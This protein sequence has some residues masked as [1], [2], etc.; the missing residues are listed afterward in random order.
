MNIGQ[1]D[2]YK[3]FKIGKQLSIITFLFFFTLNFD[4][5]TVSRIYLWYH[6]VACEN[7]YNLNIN[8][9]KAY[10]IYIQVSVYIYIYIQVSV[11]IYIS[12]YKYLSIYI[13]LYK[14]L[15]VQRFVFLQ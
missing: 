3:N 6:V 11:Y 5:K 13:S 12:I 4:L 10:S 7:I 1:T 14:H 9:V 8:M 2:I 15:C